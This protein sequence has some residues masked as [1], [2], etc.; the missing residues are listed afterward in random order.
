VG[1][2]SFGD[3]QEMGGGPQSSEGEKENVARAGNTR[4]ARKV[5]AR[6]E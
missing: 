1:W 5:L 2:A 6:F 3:N 4:W